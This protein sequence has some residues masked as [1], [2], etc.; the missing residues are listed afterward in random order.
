MLLVTSNDPV[1]PESPL[2]C[3]VDLKVDI[4][5]IEPKST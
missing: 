3:P 1:I 2:L 5:E 4:P